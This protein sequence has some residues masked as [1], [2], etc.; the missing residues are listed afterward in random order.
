MSLIEEALRRV[1]EP[2]R[3]A[4][5]AGSP[6]PG[7][8]SQSTPATAVHSWPTQPVGASSQPR[9]SNM[10][11]LLITV[12]VAVF[13]FATVLGVGGLFWISRA[14][15]GNQLVVVSA[16]PG[17]ARTP[18]AAAGEAAARLAPASHGVGTNA[19]QAPAVETSP[20]RPESR[21]A[22]A[23]QSPMTISQRDSRRP[24]NPFVL[25]GVVEG[26]G[27]PYA[28]IN[29]EIISVGEQVGNAT[30]VEI[31]EGNVRLRLPDGDE[32]ALRVSR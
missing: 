20:S 24:K 27:Q 28:V 18:S 5:D 23:M 1:P 13:G 4:E 26:L 12:A 30:L 16:P 10:T 3:D 21:P 32:V 14:M 6:R 15:R 17:G 8:A 19:A 22:P 31:A 7:G 29:G 2:A 9:T 25:S 11:D